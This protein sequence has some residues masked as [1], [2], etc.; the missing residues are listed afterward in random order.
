[1]ERFSTGSA[2]KILT[3]I[4]IITGLLYIPTTTHCLMQAHSPADSSSS[5][6]DGQAKAEAVLILQ[7]LQDNQLATLYRDQ[8]SA[9]QKRTGLTTEAKAIAMFS[10]QMMVAPGIPEKRTLIFAQRSQTLPAFFGDQQG[11]FYSYVFLSKYPSGNFQH[12]VYLVKEGERWK[13]ALLA[14]KPAF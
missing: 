4:L 8:V 9:L 11:P 2:R 1:M 6:D 13:L 3:L 7:L 5:Y 14:V 10:G 12:E